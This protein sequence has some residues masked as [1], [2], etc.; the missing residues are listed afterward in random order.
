MSADDADAWN[1]TQ[2]QAAH[3]VAQLPQAPRAPAQGPPRTIVDEVLVKE[4]YQVDADIP[5]A[6]EDGSPVVVPRARG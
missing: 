2:R 6:P 4:L 1:L 5:R 3:R